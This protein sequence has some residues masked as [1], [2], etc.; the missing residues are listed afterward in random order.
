MAALRWTYTRFSVSDR[1]GFDRVIT[2]RNHF[3]LEVDFGGGGGAKISTGGSSLALAGFVRFCCHGFGFAFAFRC[4]GFGFAAAAAL[5]LDLAA[6]FVVAPVVAFRAAGRR[7]LRP[8]FAFVP[9]RCHGLGGRFGF[10]IRFTV[11]FFSTSG[12][13]SEPKSTTN[14]RQQRGKFPQLHDEIS[15]SV[16]VRFGYRSSASFAAALAPRALACCSVK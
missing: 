3:Y 16:D 13:F 2:P 4:H 5:A 1:P 8:D 6:A 7:D 10:V 12:G 11:V 14:P 9:F 15:S